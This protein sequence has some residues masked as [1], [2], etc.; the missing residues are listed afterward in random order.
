MFSEATRL[1]ARQESR[2]ESGKEKKLDIPEEAKPIANPKPAPKAVHPPAQKT[3]PKPPP[4][5]NRKKSSGFLGFL[6]FLVILI[7]LG[8][9]G[10]KVYLLIQYKSQITEEKIELQAT[11][12]SQRIQTATQFTNPV[13]ISEPTGRTDPLAPY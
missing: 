3:I 2:P 10:Y 11:K 1:P 5:K 12:E 7:L 8:Y 4:V 6:I 9:F 13:S